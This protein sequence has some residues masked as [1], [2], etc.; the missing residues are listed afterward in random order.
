MLIL[1]TQSNNTIKKVSSIT[2][3]HMYIAYKLIHIGMNMLEKS[4]T[5]M[6]TYSHVRYKAIIIFQ[7]FS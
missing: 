3:I 7:Q 6:A 1:L 2:H 4:I 5:K